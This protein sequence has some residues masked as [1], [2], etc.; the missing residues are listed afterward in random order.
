MSNAGYRLGPELEAGVLD[1]GRLAEDL[2]VATVDQSLFDA[3]GA[4][5]DGDP[6]AALVAYANE[7]SRPAGTL[8]QGGVITTGSLCGGLAIPSAT[9]VSISLGWKMWNM[10]IVQ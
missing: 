8:L 5:P 9:T 3:P 10:E 6:L 7:A 1:E 4:H 2:R